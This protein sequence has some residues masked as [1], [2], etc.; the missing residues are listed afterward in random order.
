MK[1]QQHNVSGIG[2]VVIFSGLGSEQHVGV[3]C[4][5]IFAEI[6]HCALSASLL[7]LKPVGHL[8]EDTIENIMCEV[9]GFVDCVTR[10]NH[11]H[12]DL[13]LACEFQ[14]GDDAGTQI[15]QGAVCPWQGC[16]RVEHTA[17]IGE[18]KANKASQLRLTLKRICETK[19]FVFCDLRIDIE[20]QFMPISGHR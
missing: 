18:I 10:G 15:D 1:R 3:I 2:A 20:I 7:P 9:H 13:F 5:F 16:I 6:W 12:I 4:G 11:P 19:Y 14:T 17:I 8:A